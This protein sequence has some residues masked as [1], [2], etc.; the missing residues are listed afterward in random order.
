MK[1]PC[2]QQ[3]WDVGPEFVRAGSYGQ[4]AAVMVRLRREGTPYV[5][6]VFVEYPSRPFSTR[7]GQPYRPG[8]IFEFPAGL[9]TPI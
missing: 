9:T 1:C 2:C 8:G 5:R 6:V 3:E 7:R 4:K